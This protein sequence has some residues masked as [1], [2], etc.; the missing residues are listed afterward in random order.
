MDN[1]HS[2][3]ECRWKRRGQQKLTLLLPTP[4]PPASHS[5]MSVPVNHKSTV[6]TVTAYRQLAI[7]C[8]HLQPSHNLDIISS[9]RERVNLYCEEVNSTAKKESGI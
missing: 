1:R 9:W 8:R 3:M 4:F 2:A 6:P 5:F 7:Y